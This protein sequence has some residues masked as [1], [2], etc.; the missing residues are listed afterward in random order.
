MLLLLL[1][2]VL[3]ALLVLSLLLSLLMLVFILLPLLLQ[4]CSH[5]DGPLELLQHSANRPSKLQGLNQLLVLPWLLIQ[6]V[7]ACARGGLSV[8]QI[9]VGHSTY[10]EEK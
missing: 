9:R 5:F 8:K 1:L 6:S 7:A 3:L 2:F 4:A 10:S